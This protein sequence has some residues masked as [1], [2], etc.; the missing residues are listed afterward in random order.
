MNKIRNTK[1]PNNELMQIKKK[2][3]ARP[4]VNFIYLL[5]DAFHFGTHRFLLRLLYRGR[6]IDP[7]LSVF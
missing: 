4:S 5:T 2:K 6:L 1:W 7:F 3:E